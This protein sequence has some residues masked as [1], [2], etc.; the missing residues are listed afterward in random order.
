MFQQGCE[1]LD[2]LAP[3]AGMAMSEIGDLSGDDGT[4][5]AGSQQWPDAAG[6]AEHDTARQQALRGTIDHRIRQCPDAG[7][8]AIS[9]HAGL[10]DARDDAACLLYA[11]PSGGRQRKRFP[12]P[13]RA[14]SRQVSTA[15]MVIV[16][17]RFRNGR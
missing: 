10:D 12:A 11:R 16:I 4:H 3:H 14:T 8:D 5:L 17:D 6:M 2:E 15:S 13:T 1:M 9:A 7:I